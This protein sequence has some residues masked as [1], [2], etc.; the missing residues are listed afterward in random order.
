MDRLKK[1]T[2]GY[3]KNMNALRYALA[4]VFSLTNIPTDL[5]YL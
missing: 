4:A 2:K 3:S 1:K 5:G